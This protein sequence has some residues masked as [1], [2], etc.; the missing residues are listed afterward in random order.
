MPERPSSGRHAEVEHLV[1]GIQ[2]SQNREQDFRALFQRYYP[3]VVR[4]FFNRG[5]QP[6]EAEDLTQEVLLRVYRGL[7]DF[8]FEAHFDT[9]IFRI[10]T[11]VWKNALR[12]RDTLEGKAKHLSVDRQFTSSGRGPTTSVIEELPDPTTD[13]L[14]QVIATE[15]SR[16]LYLALA[17]L[18]PR[19][20]R[21]VVLRVGQDLKYQEIAD[22]MGVSLATVK[23]QLRTAQKRLRPLLEHHF[24]GFQAL[25]TAEED[26]P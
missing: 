9:W 11:N 14:D 5:F 12:H 15:R 6:Q 1:R 4:F 26:L 17:E 20:R 22:L 2:Q 21:C 24:S 16:L 3:P 7:E 18:P 10:V 19:M 23:T 13:P 8:C 25:T